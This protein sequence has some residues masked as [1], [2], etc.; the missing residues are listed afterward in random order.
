MSVYVCVTVHFVKE[1]YIYLF[2]WSW[3]NTS[4]DRFSPIHHTH[5][6]ITSHLFSFLYSSSSFLLP[7]ILNYFAI[8]TWVRQSIPS[9]SVRSVRTHLHRWFHSEQQRSWRVN[10]SW[11][12]RRRWRDCST[13]RCVWDRGCYPCTRFS[14][15]WWQ[16]GVL[17][18]S[19]GRVTSTMPSSHQ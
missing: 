19:S 8:Q 13:R 10:W 9:P 1:C 4:R 17:S 5:S 11:N 2:L 7:Q 18:W 14:R 15:C 12:W 6:T 3:S 16:Q